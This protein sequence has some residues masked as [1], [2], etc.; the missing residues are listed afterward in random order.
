M[1]AS[2]LDSQNHHVLQPAMSPAMKTYFDLSDRL[3]SA[4][5]EERAVLSCYRPEQVR[6]ATAQRRPCDTLPPDSPML[7]ARI[8]R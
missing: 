7:V 8:M 3:T 5:V 2:T 1:V 4:K 6:K